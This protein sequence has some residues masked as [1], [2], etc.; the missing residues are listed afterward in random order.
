M[1]ENFCLPLGMHVFTPEATM[2]FLAMDV[3]EAFLLPITRIA[4]GLC[5]Q[6]QRPSLLDFCLAEPDTIK[7]SELHW[8]NAPR[9]MRLC[10]MSV[11]GR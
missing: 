11:C 3:Q 5:A 4:P 6:T 1:L 7:C 10:T 2:S 8:E 9:I